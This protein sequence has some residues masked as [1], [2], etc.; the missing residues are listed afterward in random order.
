MSTL[1]ETNTQVNIGNHTVHIYNAIPVIEI[2]IETD[3]YFKTDG[4]F[5]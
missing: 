4:Y 5:G 2:A 1:R 3:G